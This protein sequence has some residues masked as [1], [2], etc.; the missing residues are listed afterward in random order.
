MLIIGRP[1]EMLRDLRKNKESRELSAESMEIL[2]IGVNNVPNLVI[3]LRQADSTFTNLVL[4][5][6]WLCSIILKPTLQFLGILAI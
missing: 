2:G 1:D 5:H 4:C 6:L 3:S